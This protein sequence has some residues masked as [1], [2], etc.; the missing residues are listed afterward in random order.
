MKEHPTV[1]ALAAALTELEVRYHKQVLAGDCVN[2]L[3]YKTLGYSL[4]DDNMYQAAVVINE[5]ITLWAKISILEALS[6]QDCCEY[7]R[8]FSNT[9]V[10][11]VLAS[12][13]MLLV[14]SADIFIHSSVQ[15]TSKM[16]LQC[17]Q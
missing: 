6:W 11:S 16:S 14:H 2:Y 13:D 9:A 17:L 7:I 15:Q 1:Q 3:L 8:F 12:P 5:Q 4:W 10:V